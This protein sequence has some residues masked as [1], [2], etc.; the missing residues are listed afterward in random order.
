MGG[1]FN[2]ALGP[3]NP[4]KRCLTL[5]NGHLPPH[6]C[7]FNKV[8]GGEK[9]SLGQEDGWAY[10]R[11]MGLEVVEVQIFLTPFLLLKNT[12]KPQHPPC[13]DRH[14]LRI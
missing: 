7:S 9:V 10:P 11:H 14:K 5:T 1:L 8:G 6:L 12:Q 13:K 2:A 4:V 3:V